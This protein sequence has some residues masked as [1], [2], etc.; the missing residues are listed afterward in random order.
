[1]IYDGS[2]F[3]VVGGPGSDDTFKTE[4]CKLNQNEIIC[5]EYGQELRNYAYYPE[6]IIVDASFCNY[7]K[8]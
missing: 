6:M 5:E 4:R 8:P 7:S 3:I 1:M 2:A